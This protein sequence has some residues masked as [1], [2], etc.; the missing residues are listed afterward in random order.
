ANWETSLLGT[1]S[2]LGTLVLVLAVFRRARPL[3]LTLLAIGIGI[4]CALAASLL[5]FRQLH[6][7][8][9]LF[10]ISLI[11]ISVDYCLQYFCE[12]FD[13]EAQDGTARLY[14]VLAGVTLGLGTTLIGYL[15]LLI[16]PFPLLQQ[17]SV[18]SAFGLA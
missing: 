7:I 9:L 17:V 14:R 13:G 5:I 12:Y 2:L 10:G 1:I 4:L 15:T 8:A 11:G 6:A 3:L 16:A 18:F